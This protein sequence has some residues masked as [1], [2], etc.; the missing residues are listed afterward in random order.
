[1]EK[2]RLEII[3]LSSSQSQNVRPPIIAKNKNHGRLVKRLKHIIRVTSIILRKSDKSDI[4]H[5]E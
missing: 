1:M 5:L 4:F 3:G 2:I